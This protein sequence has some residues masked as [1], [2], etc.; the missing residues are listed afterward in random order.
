[1]ADAAL[2]FNP[3]E[4]YSFISGR[5][6]TKTNPDLAF[7]KVI[8]QEPLPVR[9][10]LDRFPYSQH[11]PSLITT[12]SLVQ[13]MEGKPVWRWNFRKVNWS[14]FA[15]STN[16]AAKSLPVPSASNINNAYVAYCTM[17]TNTAKKHVPWRVQKN[18]V[19]CWD[20]ECEELL[21]AHNEAKTNAEWARTATELM[22]WFNT[23]RRERWTETVNSIDFTHSS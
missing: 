3:K 11:H 19:P 8:G 23:K 17:L 5:W 1:M 13:S 21:H 2:L 20:E 18:Y 7:A 10:V 9:R 22:T 12:P 14:E 4:P 16:T 15:N 6:N